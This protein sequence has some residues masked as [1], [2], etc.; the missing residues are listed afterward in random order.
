MLTTQTLFA[1]RAYRDGP[2][3]QRGRRALTKEA[4]GD[5]CPRSYEMRSLQLRGVTPRIGLLQSQYDCIRQ[6]CLKVFTL[7]WLS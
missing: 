4:T 3:P 2:Y 6:G 7:R 5:S 1:I